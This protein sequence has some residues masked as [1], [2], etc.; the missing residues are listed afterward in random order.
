GIIKTDHAVNHDDLLIDSTG[1]GRRRV[2]EQ[3][4]TG[5]GTGAGAIG[6]HDVA[7]GQGDL[8]Y[9]C[10]VLRLLV[11]ANKGGRLGGGGIRRVIGRRRRGRSAAG[12][13]GDGGQAG[14][15]QRRF[16]PDE[17]G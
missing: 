14:G 11:G 1:T 3:A 4:G 15:K 7:A 16:H 6:E 8:L 2:T 5:R 12:Q 9:V 17:H 10:H 13:Q